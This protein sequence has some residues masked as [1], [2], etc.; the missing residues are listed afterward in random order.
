MSKVKVIRVR[1][2]DPEFPQP[3]KQIM[4]D[5]VM[6]FDGSV[7]LLHEHALAEEFEGRSLIV[8]INSEEIGAKKLAA[9]GEWEP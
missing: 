2:L 8:Q 7:Q 5:L 3:N 6:S 9:L 1:F 4:N